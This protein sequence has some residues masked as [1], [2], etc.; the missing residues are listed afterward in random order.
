MRDSLP[1]K[2]GKSMR[3]MLQRGW[4]GDRMSV[5]RAAVVKR[6]EGY[7]SKRGVSYLWNARIVCQVPVPAPSHW[8][9]QHITRY[10]DGEKS[11]KVSGVTTVRQQI[12]TTVYEYAALTT[13]PPYVTLAS[14]S[15][16]PWISRSP[17]RPSQRVRWCGIRY[18]TT[19]SWTL[20]DLQILR[21]HAECLLEAFCC[22]VYSHGYLVY[23]LTKLGIRPI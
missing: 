1:C 18:T 16:N 5:T 6:G 12:V 8:I 9:L 17:H 19:P 22:V 20:L 21:F 7:P 15:P 13:T 4:V 23:T 3:I 11:P 10:R 2:P 14:F